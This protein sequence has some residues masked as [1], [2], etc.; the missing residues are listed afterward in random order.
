M[1]RLGSPSSQ[2]GTRS[3][4]LRRVAPVINYLVALR[5]GVVC[6]AIQTD[7]GREVAVKIRAAGSSPNAEARFDKEQKVLA[8]LHH[9]HIVPVHVSGRHGPYQYFV[10]KRIDGATLA[11]VV[12]ALADR[13]AEDR[14]RDRER[15]ALVRA[16]QGDR[17][18]RRTEVGWRD[19]LGPDTRRAAA[20]RND[21]PL[22]TRRSRPW[23]G[24][25]PSGNS[26]GRTPSARPSRSTTRA[27]S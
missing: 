1:S 27:A 21:E 20:L 18:G 4:R 6:S 14:E 10:M 26:G 17:L 11:D 8:R 15:E 23:R 19:A 24:P 12:A 13:A 7:F 22:R 5:A 9:T 2:S 25:T 16:V 3:I